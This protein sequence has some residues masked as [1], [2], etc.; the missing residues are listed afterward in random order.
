LKNY[1]RSD[2]AQAV[3]VTI[4]NVVKKFGSF[5]ALGGVDL[6]IRSGEF[7]TLLGPSGCG[8]TTLLRCTAGFE[9]P[10]S[11]RILFNDADMTHIPPWEKNIGFVFQNYALWPNKSV[12]ANIAYG[13]EIRKKNT[14]F[15]REK[16]EWALDL[17][18]LPGIG[19]KMPEQLSGGQ[20]Q[21]VAIARAL[22]IDPAILLL[23]EPLS[24]LDAKLRISLRFQ[25]R[26]IQKK[27]KI[28]AIYVTHDQEEAL[29]ISD[30]IAV[31]NAGS[32]LQVG[33]PEDIYERP[34]QRFVADFV[35][36]ANLVPGSREGDV[37]VCS[38]RFKLRL[39]PEDHERMAES[40][41]AEIMF[42]PEALRE[43]DGRGHADIEGRIIDFLYHGNLRRYMV[44]AGCDAPVVYETNIPHT[45]GDPLRLAIT[46]YR[47]YT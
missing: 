32:V 40:Q 19:E 7:F 17:L 11:G 8:K 14:S 47:L 26:E 15:I 43:I 4:E 16:V 46:Q 42:R 36:K 10:T 6:S 35:G 44:D 1:E 23:D 3:S 2:D 22:V 34:S 33:T 27:L 12:Y 25:I 5:Q 38:D 41:D 28:T 20:Q 45:V 18:G 30:R 31:M 29:E 24:N 37:F 13:L 39:S 21:R 9:R